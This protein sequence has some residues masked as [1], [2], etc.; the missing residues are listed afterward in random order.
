LA[1]ASRIPEA[2]FMVFVAKNLEELVLSK[3]LLNFS[4]CKK[5][6]GLRKN[7]V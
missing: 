5:S 7:R 3:A 6:M 4:F 2:I 1:I